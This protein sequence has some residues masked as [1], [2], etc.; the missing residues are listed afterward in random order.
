MDKFCKFEEECAY[1][2]MEDTRFE[3]KKQ[4]ITL[5]HKESR[6]ELEIK[7][8]QDDVKELRLE[9]KLLAAF[10]KKLSR[11]SE[12][13]FLEKVVEKE[14]VRQNVPNINKFKCDKCECSFRK[15]ITLEKHKK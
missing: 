2:H 14:D 15:E 7:K 9:I 8:F 6:H 1:L 11:N 13:I 4:V 12:D 10:S 5:D 3:V